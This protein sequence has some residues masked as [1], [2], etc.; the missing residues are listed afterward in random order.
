MHM[1]LWK[2]PQRRK[3]ETIRRMGEKKRRRK[4]KMLGIEKDFLHSRLVGY[5]PYLWSESYC[6]QQSC[7]HYRFFQLWTAWGS[8]LSCCCCCMLRV[9]YLLFIGTSLIQTPW[10]P[11]SGLELVSFF[12]AQRSHFAQWCWC[13]F[14]KDRE[15]KSQERHCAGLL[16]VTTCEE[17]WLISWDH[18]V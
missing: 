2:L 4:K 5:K 10:S 14:A 9:L 15:V 12:I 1:L 13:S 7:G 6:K 16:L 8:R 17:S 3:T 11:V 18:E